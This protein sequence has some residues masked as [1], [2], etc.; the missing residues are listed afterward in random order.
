[1]WG[2]SGR[3]ESIKNAAV[4]EHGFI[5]VSVLLCQIPNIAK[6]IEAFKKEVEAKKK[7]PEWIKSNRLL[8][9]TWQLFIFSYDF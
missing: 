6:K 9:F 2:D 8:D 4:Q 5:D 3:D 1:M 7:P